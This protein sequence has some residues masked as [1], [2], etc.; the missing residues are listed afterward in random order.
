MTLK[1][2]RPAGDGGPRDRYQ[3]G[4]ETPQRYAAEPLRARAPTCI[5]RE[6]W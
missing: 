2:K 3:S 6:V 1:R 5:M 4:R